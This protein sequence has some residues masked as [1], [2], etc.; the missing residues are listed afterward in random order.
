MYRR[1]VIHAENAIRLFIS[2]GNDATHLV[3]TGIFWYV[4]IPHE[5]TLQISAILSQYN[6]VSIET[7]EDELKAMME[8]TPMALANA[9]H[10]GQIVHPG[11]KYQHVWEAVCKSA[12][13][14][15]V[16][17]STIAQ[18]ALANG[19]QKATVAVAN[20]TQKATVAVANVAQKATVA[21]ANGAQ[22]ATVAAA[23][24]VHYAFVCCISRAIK[25]YNS[26]V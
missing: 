25:V 22:K 17:L 14:V 26:P 23:N 15:E 24:G 1:V 6:T 2:L 9:I 19:V 20:V 16:P 7:T 21:V 3:G 4:I 10:T 11:R 12:G 13:I 18:H 8:A 5:I